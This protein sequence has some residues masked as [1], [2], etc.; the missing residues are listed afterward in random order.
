MERVVGP[1]KGLPREVL[2][3]PSLEM[4]KEGLEVA[5]SA[6]GWGQV[7][8]QKQQDLPRTQWGEGFGE[9][10]GFLLLEADSELTL[11]PPVPE[12]GHIRGKQSPHQPSVSHELVLEF[13]PPSS[14]DPVFPALALSG[15]LAV[16]KAGL[17]GA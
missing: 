12:V 9:R 17:D 8:A 2:E 11:P 10:L 13:S 16:R 7:L 15:T 1:W 5:L 14:T 4:P 3:C 6:L